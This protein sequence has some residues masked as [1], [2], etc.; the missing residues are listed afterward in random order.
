MPTNYI[1]NLKKM[2]ISGMRF[3]ES[4]ARHTTFRI[5]GP[6]EAF[7][8][9]DNGADMVYIFNIINNIEIPYLVLG[10]GSNLLVSD[11]GVNKLVIMMSSAD[12]QI[13][14]RNGNIIAFSGSTL[15]QLVNTAAKSGLSGLEFAVGIPGSLGG[16]IVM[17][18][19]AFGGEFSQLTD[20]VEVLDSSG[21]VIRLTKS[22]CDFS[23]RRSSIGE[24]GGIILRAGLKLIESESQKVRAQMKLNVDKRGHSF[25]ENYRNAGSIWKNPQGDYAGRLIDAAGLKGLSRGDAEI[26]NVHANFIVNRGSASSEDVIYLMRL[27]KKRVSEQFGVELEPEIK[28]WGFPG[29]VLYDY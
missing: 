9:V 27:T 3:D 15:P 28:L 24:K 1:D 8:A 2:N 22:E 18:A 12:P 21:N 10:R 13:D 19:G 4:L 17:N 5:G 16:A 29:G 26:S 14:I 7:C 25:P 11:G 23:Y 6:A 20:W